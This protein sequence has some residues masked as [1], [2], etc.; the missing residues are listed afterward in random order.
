MSTLA[1][2]GQQIGDQV[3]LPTV[4]DKYK[5]AATLK[6][7]NIST[8]A[9]GLSGKP[10]LLE[11]NLKYLVTWG[12]IFTAL[13]PGTVM[14]VDKAVLQFVGTQVLIFCAVAF[15]LILGVEDLENAGFE[16]AGLVNMNKYFNSF[17]PFVISLYIALTL[18]RW[19]ILRVQCLGAV[20]DCVANLS[21]VFAVMLPGE[22]HRD[23]RA[24]V[25]KWGMASIFLLA[26]CAREDD[27]LNS[28]VSKGLLSAR[29][30][31]RIEP[32]SLAGRPMAMF[33]WI[34]RTAQETFDDDVHS[35]KP[36]V[37][38]WTLVLNDC[39]KGRNAIQCVYTYL[40]TQLPYA[41]VHLIGLLVNLSNFIAAAK[42]GASFAVAVA[43][44]DVAEAIFQLLNMVAPVLYNGMLS[45]SYAVHDPLGEDM[46]DFPIAAFTE[47]VAEMVD[48]TLAAQDT[49]E[50]ATVEHI[51]ALKKIAESGHEK[52][53]R[54]S[55]NPRCDNHTAL[56]EMRR[57]SSS[58]V[59]GLGRVSKKVEMLVEAI[60]KGEKQRKRDDGAFFQQIKES[61]WA[62]SMIATKLSEPGAAKEGRLQENPDKAAMIPG[63]TAKEKEFA[64]PFN[65]PIDY[66]Q[67]GRELLKTVNL[68]HDGSR[69]QYSN[70]NSIFRHPRTNALLFV[71]NV[72]IACSRKEL[73]ELNITRIVYCQE[74]NEGKM[75]FK[76]DPQFKYLPF[77][78]GAWGQSVAEAHRSG[79]KFNAV[80]Y[81]APLF[82]FVESEL[83]D[84]RNVLIH[85]L[86][87]A[88]RAGTAGVACLMHLCD[89]DRKFAIQIAKAARPVI[90]PIGDFP[91]LLQALDVARMRAKQTAEFQRT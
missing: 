43:R 81:F 46:L 56:E 16:T 18:Y 88:H 28:M 17:I 10:K 19:W 7:S 90:D 70:A 4:A 34:L 5:Q 26:K 71:G 82:E 27:N 24:N 29:E 41:Y 84:G 57:V 86:A 9:F 22:K 21:A 25:I 75:N 49:F 73:G 78:I 33:A 69:E 35:P 36:H 61:E 66:A 2:D 8:I 83:N 30:V 67:A 53:P 23:V 14:T 79:G 11:Y 31:E 76:A 63:A 15:S 39:M 52:A 51:N 12:G 58:I 13:A 6:K 3:H 47:Y 50:Q 74:P 48:A 20:F 32:M 80:V 59:A 60:H 89:V 54:K 1:P 77:N 37:F 65:R 87:G 91:Q 55:V 45:I 85:C 62:F 38:Q 40:N 72:H 68:D 42:C 64:R 44:T